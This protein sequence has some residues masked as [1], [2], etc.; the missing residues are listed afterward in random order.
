MEENKRF[1]GKRGI[2]CHI[3]LKSYSANRATTLLARDI[4]SKLV[5]KLRQTRLTSD[6]NLKTK[7][8]ANPVFTTVIVKA[9]VISKAKVIKNANISENFLPV[10]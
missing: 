3:V 2:S 8:S 1:F 9:I 10:E 5:G 6:K 4:V 7:P